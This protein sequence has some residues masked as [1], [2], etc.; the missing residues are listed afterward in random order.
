MA[1]FT[2]T[3]LEF[4]AGAFH[5]NSQ[6]LQ[7]NGAQIEH[8]TSDVVALTSNTKGEAPLRH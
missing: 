7:C 5:R 6:P 4:E 1:C 3:L 8:I 2:Q